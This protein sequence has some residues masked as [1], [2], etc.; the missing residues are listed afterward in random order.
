MIG[1]IIRS[2]LS[3]TA[4]IAGG[5][6]MGAVTSA[7]AADFGGDCCADLEER[8]AVLEATTARKGNRKVSLTIYGKVNQAIGFWDDGFDDDTYNY[9]NDTSRTRIGFKGKAKINSDWWAGYKIEIGIRSEDQGAIDQDTDDGNTG[10]D[11]RKAEWTLGS[12]TYGSITMGESS[13]ATDG[14]TQ[15]QTA[16]IKHFANPDVLDANDSFHIR[17]AGTGAR[18]GEWDNLAQVFEPGEGSRGNL[19]RYDSPTFAGFKVS[20]AWGEDD[21]WNVALRYKGKFQD[22]KVAAGIGYGEA[23]ENDEECTEAV[24]AGNTVS[25][26]QELGMSASLM[27]TPTGLFVTG[28]YGIRWDEGRERL[29]ASRGFT[30]TE[31]EE[32]KFWHIQAGIEGKWNSLGKTT[33]FGGYYD[34]DAGHTVRDNNG[35]ANTFGGNDITNFEFDMWEI[36]FNQHISAAAMDLYIHYKQYDADVTTTVGAVDTEEW[37]TLIVGGHI[38]F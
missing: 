30:G 35:N 3:L 17:E 34:R 9:T 8:V 14:I 23:D 33:I 5:V 15:I 24:I 6:M 18:V 36:G 22:F 1:G 11:L 10:F 27:H 29:L 12:K 26:C 20:A 16:K 7:Q 28:A 13:F 37:R 31:A 4:L 32:N 2:G 25:D 38:K 19:V 21:I